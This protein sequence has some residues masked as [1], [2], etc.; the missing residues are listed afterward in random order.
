MSTNTQRS[1]GP[2][3]HIVPGVRR[4]AG[5]L[6]GLALVAGACGGGDEPPGDGDASTSPT[7]SAAPTDPPAEPT[8]T[9]EPS[10]QA[11][12][13]GD[14]SDDTTDGETP[15]SDEPADEPEAP[16]SDVPPSDVVAADVDF[17]D[18]ELA[19]AVALTD[20]PTLLELHASA[21]TDAT[22]EPLQAAADL[23]GFPI[24]LR[25]PTDG[26]L[27]TVEAEVSAI[28]DG[29]W[30]VAWTYAIQNDE[31][32][33]YQVDAD[34]NPVGPPVDLINATYPDRWL[35]QGLEF[36]NTATYTSL[37]HPSGRGNYQLYFKPVGGTEVELVTPAGT[38]SLGVVGVA[39][40][41]DFDTSDNVEGETPQPGYFMVTN[42]TFAAGVVPVPLM[43][44]ILNTIP[45]TDTMELSN[46]RLATKLNDPESMFSDYGT[47]S[48]HLRVSYEVPA[49][50]FDS[51]AAYFAADPFDASTIRMVRID[52][53]A[54]PPVTVDDALDPAADRPRSDLLLVDR[55]PGSVSMS[56]PDAGDETFLVRFE[57]ELEPLRQPLS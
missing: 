24:G 1:G 53:F 35:E 43:E 39:A 55:Y 54:E 29:L 51:V 14:D 28:P 6:V 19:G 36:Q 4:V 37:E 22:I 38:G 45:T 27:I 25:A 52:A 18:P 31:A 16:S 46:A 26:P 32:A 21:Y 15:G 8:A 33:D 23:T 50:D 12:A 47:R 40:E 2:G 5:A 10:P 41:S 42:A 34:D 9:P 3:H 44:A 56:P 57:F 7:V 13:A 48:M 30:E 20:I 49:A 11:P 17:S